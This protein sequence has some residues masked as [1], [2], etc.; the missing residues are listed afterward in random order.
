MNTPDDALCNDGQSCNGVETCDPVNDCQ[1][2][3]PPDCDDSVECTDD[4]CNEVTD[5]CDNTPND[6]N[7]ANGDFC[8]GAETCDPVNDCQAGTPPDW[9]DSVECTDDS[10]NEVTDECDN[11]PNDADCANGDFCDGVETCDPVNDCQAGTPPDCDDSVECT[12]D[13]CNEVTDECDNTPNDGNCDDSEFCNGVETCDPVSDCQAG[14][15]VDC[16]DGVACTD[17][18]CNEDTDQCDNTPN[19]SLCDDDTACTED[20]CHALL[21]CQFVPDHEVCADAVECTDDICIPFVGCQ[22]VPNNANC[23]DGVFC[24]D[25]LC[26]PEDNCSN[27]PNDFN[28]DQTQNACTDP[29]TCH[30]ELDCLPHNKPCS[31]FTDSSLCEF[32]VEPTKGTCDDG[33]GCLW[34]VS[35]GDLGGAFCT[36]SG[37][38]LDEFGDPLGDCA[39]DPNCGAFC[40]SSRQF[41][42]LFRPDVKNYPAHR[43]NAT[44]PGQFFYNLNAE[45]TPGEEATFTISV[46]Y[47]FVTQGARPV[48]VHDSDDV[49]TVDGCFAPE[50][51]MALDL[52]IS[53]ADYENGIDPGDPRASAY[54]LHCD[55]PFCGPDDQ[56]LGFSCTFD[57]TTA[58]PP[59]GMTY[60]NVHLDYGLKGP[61]VDAN[62]CDG[63]EDRYDRGLTPSRWDT[64][65]A[66]I[67]DTLQLAIV[68]CQSYVFSHT[69]GFD[70]SG[71][72][73]VQNLNQF[74]QI[75]G[76]FGSVSTAADCGDTGQPGYLVRLSRKSAVK[77]QGYTDEDG[78]YA[79]HY[80]HKGPPEAVQ[81]RAL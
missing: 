7:C 80:K 40:Q 24:T 6:A 64:W 36:A 46:P 48:H 63:L 27:T 61:H 68:D 11:T 33:S 8:D 47:P 22:S 1:A 62:P 53:L 75:A 5:E 4:S 41:R 45:G 76:V 38:C 60:I 15:P 19:D 39:P 26:D 12:D 78:S 10:C 35:C 79:L 34:D 73:A 31:L 42:L 28:C 14:T 30:P 55:S 44:N 9:D 29:D 37:E 54:N 81:S 25:D 51:G 77:K 43:C 20:F 21:G 58:Y 23:D 50:N 69:D 13:S 3:T 74:K 57:V 16:N 32:D 17:D 2:G 67:D 52:T 70:Q 18:S 56:Q 72:N 49:M 65:D 71:E 66:L 59:G